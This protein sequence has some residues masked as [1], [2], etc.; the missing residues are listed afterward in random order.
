MSIFK[1]RFTIREYYDRDRPTFYKSIQSVR[2]N[3]MDMT[4]WLDYFVTGLETQKIEVRKR[5]E[6]VIRRDVLVKHHGLN[7]RQAKALGHLTKQG[8]LTS[9]IMKRSARP[10][11]AAA[12]SGT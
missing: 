11:T 7:E 1:P 9:R 6:Q 10:S 12:C 4:G 2:E 5:S 8:Q 3:A